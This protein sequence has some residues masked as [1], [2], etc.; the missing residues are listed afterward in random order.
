MVFMQ[1]NS[2]TD[3]TGLNLADYFYWGSEDSAPSGSF[4][5]PK[6]CNNQPKQD[7]PESCHNCHLPLN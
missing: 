1:S 4:D 7:V 3:G 6:I 5:L 2:N